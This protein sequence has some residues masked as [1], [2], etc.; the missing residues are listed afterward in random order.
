M[1]LVQELKHRHVFR[2]AIAYCGLGWVVLQFAHIALPELGFPGWIMPTLVLIGVFGFPFVLCFAWSFEFTSGGL[3][4]REHVQPGESLVH[5]TRA[6]LNKVIT[7]FLLLALLLVLAEN[8][9][10]LL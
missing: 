3:K 4:R 2:A 10:P 8:Y 7:A 9:F 6:T 1:S 5:E